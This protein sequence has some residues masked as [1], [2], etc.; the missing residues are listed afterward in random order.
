V[1]RNTTRQAAETDEALRDRLRNV[2]D[3]LTR[4]TLI[5]AI[6]SILDAEVITYDPLVYPGMVEMPRDASFFRTLASDTGTGGTFATVG[7]GVVKFTPDTPF[8]GVPFRDIEEAITHK[9]VISGAAT[10]GN[11]GTHVATGI[12]VDGVTYAPPGGYADE[13]DATVTWTVEKYDRD[14][15]LMDGF[16]DAFFAGDVSP[17]SAVQADRMG[18]QLPGKVVIILP[19]GCT[20]GTLASVQEMLRQKKGAGVLALVE[21]RLNA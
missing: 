18:Q 13:V 17:G 6:A 10:A 5:A 15:N 19:F 2:P 21:C 16:Q 8:Q 3:A 4:P 9:L 11:D 7:A 20:A 14:D 1:D 12:D